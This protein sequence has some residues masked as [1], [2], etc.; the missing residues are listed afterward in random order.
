MSRRAG[1]LL[2]VALLALAVNLMGR[3]APLASTLKVGDLPPQKLTWQVNLSDY[4]G[5]IVIISFWASWCPPCRKELPI[6]AAIQKQA[7]RDK[8]VVFAFNW[9]EDED[10]FWQLRRALNGLGLTLLSDS[11]GNIGRQYGVNALPHMV[12]IGRDGRVAAIHVGYD[13]SEIPI[14]VDEINSLWRQPAG[15]PPEAQAGRPPG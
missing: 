9:R 2:A 11:A 4:R 5:K 8:L 12:I 13:D 14:L 3:A 15:V 1:R 6:L 7:T 10:R